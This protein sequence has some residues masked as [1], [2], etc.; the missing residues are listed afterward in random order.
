MKIKL[1]ARCIW[2]T[3]DLGDDVSEPKDRLALDVLCSAVPPE[4]LSTLT[5]K[6]TTRLAWESINVKRIGDDRMRKTTM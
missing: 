6:P 1:Q 3:I 5:I 4:M 2:R